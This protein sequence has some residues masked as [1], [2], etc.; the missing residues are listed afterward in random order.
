MEK[1][2]CNMI[3]EI[4]IA[5]VL[6]RTGKSREWIKEHYEE[7]RAKHAGEVFVVRDEQLVATSKNI[8]E[9][10]KEIEKKGENPTF[11]VMDSIPPK[12]LS[13]IL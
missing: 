11:L 2:T 8:L 1:V 12:G 9:L 5:E 6:K 10:L 13:F 7:L 4:D 3:E